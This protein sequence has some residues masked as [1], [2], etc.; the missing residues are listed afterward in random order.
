MTSKV[1]K[2]SV[3]ITTN[4]AASIREAVK[5]GAYASSSDVIRDAL[6]LWEDKREHRARLID[7]AR[8]LW[9]HG[10]ASGFAEPAEPMEDIIA[11]ARAR[12]AERG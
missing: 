12:R 3:S 11:R 2:I 9:D 10:I 8:Q 5:E 7:N 4:Q 6:R 1:Q